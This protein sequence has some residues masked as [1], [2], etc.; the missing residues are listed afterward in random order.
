M[1][2]DVLKHAQVVDMIRSKHKASMASI[3]FFMKRFSNFY[4]FDS[5]SIE[6]EFSRFE[7]DNLPRSLVE[8][9]RID[10]AW[11]ELGKVKP[12][13]CAALKYAH[14]SKLMLCILVIPHSN[15]D[16]ERVFSGVRKNQTD[17]RPNLSVP[18]LE[19]LLMLKTTML[20]DKTAAMRES[21]PMLSS[22]KPKVQHVWTWH[23]QIRLM[24]TI[25]SMIVK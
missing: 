21:S 17:F 3:R 9:N 4:H 20:N 14:L 23:R 25:T 10:V 6:A 2:Q 12:P 18:T 11:S 24:R 8:C 22:K 15:A 7:V 16:S 5:D 13:D 1:H 19:S